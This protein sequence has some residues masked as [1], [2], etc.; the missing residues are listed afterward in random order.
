MP[1]GLLAY[2]VASR[3]SNTT[4]RRSISRSVTS[5]I[6]AVVIIVTDI[7]IGYPNSLLQW[8]QTNHFAGAS[9]CR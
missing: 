4:G 6:G 8:Y 3:K 7:S 5:R 2:R 9:V 1:V